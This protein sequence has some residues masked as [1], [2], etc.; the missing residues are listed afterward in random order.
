MR[1]NIFLSCIL[2][3]AVAKNWAGTPTP[4]GRG[5]IF[6]TPD[7]GLAGQLNMY[8]VPG[9]F[10]RAIFPFGTGSIRGLR[11]ATGDLNGDGFPDV[12]VAEGESDTPEVRAF[13]G[14]NLGVEIHRFLAFDPGTG[15][16]IGLAAGNYNGDQM[17]DIVVGSGP[18]LEAHV[19]VVDGVTLADLQSFFAFP[20][21]S[22]GINVAS[23][24]VN[25]DGFHDTIVAP[26]SGLAPEVRVFDGRNPENQIAAFLAFSPTFLGGVEVASGDI[27]GD[28]LADIIVGSGTGMAPTVKTFDAATL[29]EVRTFFA[30]Q[31]DQTG[32]VRVSAVDLNGDGI[33]EIVTGPGPGAPPQINRFRADGTFLGGLFA[34]SSNHTGG[35]FVASMRAPEIFT[36]GEP[37][38]LVR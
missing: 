5:V 2:F 22:G 20:G 15:G 3:F 25:G 21:F 12:I 33:M 29:Q 11:V 36:L 37:G 31:L 28:G 17:D 6:T 9:F 19:R 18:G 38:I 24:D 7:A 35:V 1:T 14:S 16:G 8:S 4:V 23:G 30:Y 26:R 10:E 34:Y 32:G 27:N 13:D